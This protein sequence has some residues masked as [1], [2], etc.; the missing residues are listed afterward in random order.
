MC[1]GRAKPP[2]KAS[3]TNA[4]LRCVQ[5]YVEKHLQSEF[6]PLRRLMSSMLPIN[7]I[8]RP[9]QNRSVLRLDCENAATTSRRL[10]RTYRAAASQQVSVPRPALRIWSYAHWARNELSNSRAVGGCNSSLQ[11]RQNQRHFGFEQRSEGLCANRSDL[12]DFNGAESNSTRAT[13]ASRRSPARALLACPVTA[14]DLAGYQGDK[15]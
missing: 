8:L 2:T 13:V 7:L 3:C 10:Q 15:N 5:G 4:R 6:A 14:P 12:F 1:A 9:L 11:S